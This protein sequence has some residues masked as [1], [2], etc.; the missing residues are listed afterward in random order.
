M[1]LPPFL[2]FASVVLFAGPFLSAAPPTARPDRPNIILFVTDDQ[3][4]ADLG[5]F[6]SP[7]IATPNLDRLAAEGTRFTDFYVAQAVCTASRAAF[8][9]GCYP[10]RIGLTGAL[11]HTSRVGLHPDEEILPEIL[12]RLGYATACFGKWHLGTVLEFFPTRHGFHEFFGLPYSNDNSS[13]HPVLADSMPPLPLYQGETILEL[14]PDQST[15][16]ARLTDHAIDF[17]ERHRDRPFFLY[18]P[19]IMPHV[20]LFAS[21]P[22]RGRSRGGLYGDTIEELDASVG[23]LLATLQRLHLDDNTLF[24]FFSDNG[25]FLSYGEHA[26]SAQ[27]LREGKLTAFEGGVRSP[28]ILRWPARIPAGRVSA[29]PWMS[30]DLL[31]T[32]C[33]LLSAPLP[34]LP[35]DGRSAAGLILDRPSATSPHE[36]LFFYAGSELHAVRS[37]RWKLHFPH[38]YLTVAAEPGV[39]G[40][41]SNWGRLT[42]KSI[43]QSGLEG[44]ASRHGYR[45]EYLR[46]PHLYD[47]ATDPGETVNLASTHPEV[48]ARLSALAAP[49]RAQLGD[50]L[51][52]VPGSALRPAG[53]LP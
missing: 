21:A 1:P 51:T 30:I 42:A 52:G 41:P 28:C 39:G 45:V 46:E 6:G 15:F 13:F 4:Y 11:N 35:I 26:G 19:H 16:T 48:V 8:L 23:R 49:L 34:T 10:N 12:Q 3:G 47:L 5:C 20:P 7:N 2:R 29:E 18:L 37:G 43:T 44:I 40:K 17:L 9:S 50:S 31:P 27:P 14:D 22:Y 53:L 33:E 36:A 32:M 24:L 38:P 25:P